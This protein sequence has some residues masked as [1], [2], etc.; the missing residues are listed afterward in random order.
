MNRIKK[1]QCIETYKKLMNIKKECENKGQEIEIAL[2]PEMFNYLKEI[3]M[4]EPSIKEIENNEN[5]MEEI[6]YE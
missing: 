5:I 2:S 3:N 6:I 4:L 1:R